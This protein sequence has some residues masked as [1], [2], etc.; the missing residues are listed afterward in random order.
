ML[1]S[2]FSVMSRVALVS[3]ML[4]APA[5]AQTAQTET[6]AAPAAAQPQ[7]AAVKEF[8]IG[9]D[10]APVTIYEYA[11]LTCSH[12]A[13]F[14]REVFPTLK[15]EYIDTGKVRFVQREVYFDQF[16]LAAAMISRC[17]AGDNADKYFA[18][19]GDLFD[20]QKDW[21]G[22]GKPDQIA[23]NLKKKGIAAGM[24]AEQVDACF[25]DQAMAEAMVKTYQDNATKDGIEGTPT[26]VINGEKVKNGPWEG[27]KAKIDE[28]LAA[29]K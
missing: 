29:V 19:S 17:A 22:E 3:V 18:V 16:G 6:P 26:F 9:Q 12:C 20:T 2:S 10:N 28:K 7:P 25:A 11:S 27:L 13:V 8:A 1:M 14:H 5:M 15:A 4:A 24:T 21:I 23:E